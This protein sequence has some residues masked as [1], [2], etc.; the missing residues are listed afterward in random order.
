MSLE[1]QFIRP[2]TPIAGS[3]DTLPVDL[4]NVV[5][6]RIVLLCL[7]PP[8]LVTL[9]NIVNLVNSYVLGITTF[10]YTGLE[11]AHD[12]VITL[13]SLAVAWTVHRRLLS[14]WSA[15]PEQGLMIGD[16]L[17]DLMAGRAAGLGT[18]YV[19]RTG[20]FPF[21]A[22]AD[23]QVQELAELTLGLEAPA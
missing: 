15:R 6:K 4:T 13:I 16:F 23:V 11:A 7:T 18:V 9:G 10:D 2:T 3:P 8:A 12:V 14:K 22:H 17:F 19:D 1:T 5:L 20:A 21:A